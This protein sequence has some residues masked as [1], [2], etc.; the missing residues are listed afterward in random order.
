[1]TTVPRGN[2]ILSAHRLEMVG[3]KWFSIPVV[4]RSVERHS[5][6]AVG[7]ALGSAVH[8]QHPEVVVKRMIL[9]HEKN[10]VTQIGDS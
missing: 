1:M 10:N 6:D 8:A 9:L 4:E 3:M 5:I 2:Q 7:Q